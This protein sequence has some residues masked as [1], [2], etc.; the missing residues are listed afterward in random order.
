MKDMIQKALRTIKD[1]GKPR[2]PRVIQRFL[3]MKYH[4][5]LEYKVLS[6]RMDLA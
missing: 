6:N 2:S 5:F 1:S 3:K 4:V